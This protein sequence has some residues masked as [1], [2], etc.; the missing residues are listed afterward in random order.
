MEGGTGAPAS[1]EPGN[2]IRGI[3]GAFDLLI[4]LMLM[5]KVFD[6]R[7]RTHKVNSGKKPKLIS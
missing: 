7:G 3:A 5:L 2:D 6:R 1:P 4:P